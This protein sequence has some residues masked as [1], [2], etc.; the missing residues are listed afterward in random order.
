MALA[1]VAVMDAAPDAAL[2][3]PPDVLPEDGDGEECDD[4][5]GDATEVGLPF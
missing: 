3:A 5:P 2:D 4:T 1:D